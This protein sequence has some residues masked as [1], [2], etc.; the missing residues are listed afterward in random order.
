MPVKVTLSTIFS[1]LALLRLP[2]VEVRYLT[3]LFLFLRLFPVK[4]EWVSL[5]LAE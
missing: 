5:S 3:A 1:T 2:W 4:R